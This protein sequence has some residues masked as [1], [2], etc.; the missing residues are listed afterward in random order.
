MR[1]L[2]EKIDKRFDK[3]LSRLFLSQD[4]DEFLKT[5]D[6]LW[7]LKEELLEIIVNNSSVLPKEIEE[8]DD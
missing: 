2:R 3:L 8:D 6:E 7:K 1:V 4:D 5:I